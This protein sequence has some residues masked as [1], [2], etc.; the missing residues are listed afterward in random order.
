MDTQPGGTQQVQLASPPWFEQARRLTADLPARP[1]IGWRLQF[2]AADPDGGHQRWHQVVEDGRVVAWDSGDVD[3]PELELRWSQADARAVFR[4]ELDGTGAL[5]AARV[6]TPGG[7]EGAAPPLDMTETSEMGSLPEVPGAT[8]VIQ[9]EFS[10][11]PFGA[12]SY[13][14]SFEDGRF[15]GADFGRAEEADVTVGITWQ[16]M[17]GVRRGQITILEALEHGGRI[18]GALG[19]IMLL[20]GLEES[21]ELHAVE[22][23][24]G[25]AGE[26]LARVGEVAATPEHTA[27]MA[28]LAEVTA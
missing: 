11:G 6:V 4:Q 23:A 26:V 20:A 15:A 7:D 25:P 9:F 5:A 12:V 24:C 27:A 13:W 21:P 18:D 10:H 8:L 17:V 19:P 16:K 2:D 28:A 3:A 22:L 1:G 14:L